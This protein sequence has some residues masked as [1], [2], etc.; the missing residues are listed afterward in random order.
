MS[1]RMKMLPIAAAIA[2]M[3][4]FATQATAATPAA[5]N[6]ASAQDANGIEEVIVTARKREESIQSVPV[7]IT[8]IS[9]ESLRQ[10]AVQSLE[11]IRFLA[12]A[13][14]VSP[15]SLGPATPCLSMRGQRQL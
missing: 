9:T 4:M 2:S 3:S 11:D 12:P 13:F 7:A 1:T 8:A 10:N 15:S 6:Q 14:Q 5:G